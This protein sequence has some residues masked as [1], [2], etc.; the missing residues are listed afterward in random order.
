[1]GVGLSLHKELQKGQ[2]WLQAGRS[3]AEAGL[4]FQAAL[5]G[6]SRG[7]APQV[8]TLLCFFLGGARLPRELLY[9]W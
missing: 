1:M 5:I 4:A 9:S 6:T 3:P 2:G 8:H 7:L